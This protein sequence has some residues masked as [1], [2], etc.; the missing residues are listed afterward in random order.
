MEQLGAAHVRLNTLDTS[1]GFWAYL[2]VYQAQ[3][4]PL[5]TAWA[6]LKVIKVTETLTRDTSK[7]SEVFN[8]YSGKISFQDLF[9]THKQTKEKV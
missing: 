5:S 9:V 8:D 3:E 6:N 2:Q 1:K 7:D 4:T